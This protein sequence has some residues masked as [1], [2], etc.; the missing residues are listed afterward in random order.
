VVRKHC[1]GLGVEVLS[2]GGYGRIVWMW[3]G[4]MGVKKYIERN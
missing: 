3:D 1:W 4:D 2:R